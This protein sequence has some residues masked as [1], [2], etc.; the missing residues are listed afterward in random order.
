[1]DS[2]KMESNVLSYIEDNKGQLFATLSEL[3]QID[4]QNFKSMGNENQ[5]QDY[6]E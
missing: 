3:I 1:M 4:T 2:N 6:L 5:G